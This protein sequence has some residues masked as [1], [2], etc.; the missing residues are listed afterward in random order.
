MKIRRH[1]NNYEGSHLF[2]DGFFLTISC[3]PYTFNGH[4]GKFEVSL[5][6]ADSTGQSILADLSFED[7]AGL[8]QDLKKIHNKKIDDNPPAYTFLTQSEILR[9]W[10]RENG[11]HVTEVQVSTQPV[12]VTGLPTC[13]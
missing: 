2:E 13:K 5:N 4:L 8:I 9:Q 10:A 7:V 3:L 11:I 6:D 12:D 1:T